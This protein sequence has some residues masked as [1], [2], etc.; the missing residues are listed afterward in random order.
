MTR[1]VLVVLF[2]ATAALAWDD[3]TGDRDMPWLGSGGRARWFHDRSSCFMCPTGYRD[4][5]RWGRSRWTGEDPYTTVGR[6]MRFLRDAHWLERWPAAIGAGSV[7]G[8]GPG[9]IEPRALPYRLTVVMIE[10]TVVVMRFDLGSLVGLPAPKNAP[11]IGTPWLNQGVELG[12][13]IPA[14]GTLLW[15]SPDAKQEPAPVAMTGDDR[16]E[17]VVQG[18]RLVL[19]RR[20]GTWQVTVPS[21]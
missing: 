6:A 17:I 9:T 21:R 20:G 13:R 12:T 8:E 2:A 19:D 10:P 16:G 11:T 18:K 15:F 7:G 14:T 3:V 1:A 4:A 5:E